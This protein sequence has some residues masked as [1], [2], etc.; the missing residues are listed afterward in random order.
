MF[1]DY[2]E[3]RSRTEQT[4]EENSADFKL[5][6]FRQRVAVDISGRTLASSM[7]GQQV[8]LPVAL[9]PVRLLG[10]QCADGEIKVARRS[11]ASP[12]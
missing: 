2:V 11:L 9:A 1:Y 4:F 10:M 7:I 8:T 6:H 5:I 3:A 12:G